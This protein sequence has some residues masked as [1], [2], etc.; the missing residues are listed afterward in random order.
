M[1][2]VSKSR[3]VSES[4]LDVPF[5]REQPNEHKHKHEYSDCTDEHKKTFEEISC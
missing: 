4:T 1:A 5:I 2:L 3:R